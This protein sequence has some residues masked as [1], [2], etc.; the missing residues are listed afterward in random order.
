[1][2]RFI[3]GDCCEFKPAPIS[4]NLRKYRE[5][6]KVVKR[7]LGGY[8]ELL[9]DKKNTGLGSNKAMTFWNIMG[10]NPLPQ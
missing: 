4:S 8:Q 7:I 5:T 1:M 10:I 9:I 3:D 2:C 6:L